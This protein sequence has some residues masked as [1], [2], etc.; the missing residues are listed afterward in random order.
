MPLRENPKEDDSLFVPSKMTKYFG[1]I[2][3]PSSCFQTRFIPLQ[4]ELRKSIAVLL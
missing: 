1:A 2:C 4:E 3:H